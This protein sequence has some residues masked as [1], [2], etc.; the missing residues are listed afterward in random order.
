M[1]MKFLLLLLGIF[2]ITC[3][4]AVPATTGLWQNNSTSLT[5]TNGS[6]AGF[7]YYF[8]LS[9]PASLNIKLYD[10]SGN[11]VYTFLDTQTSL[12]FYYNNAPI[13]IT[14]QIYKN[15]GN[16]YLTFSANDGASSVKT[17]SLTVNPT[18]A[19]TPTNSTPVIA[20]IPPQTINENTSYNYQINALDPEGDRITYSLLPS[21]LFNI[22]SSG[23]I[24]GTS[25]NVAADTNYTI[26]IH[27]SDGLNVA[28]RT[29]NLTVKDV[30]AAID[31]TAPSIQFVL[32]T[33]S[34]NSNLFQ[35]SI[36]VNIT[37]SDSGSG[38]KNITVYLYDSSRNLINNVTSISSPFAFTFYGNSNNVA[39]SSGTYYINA[40]AFDIAGNSNSTE[41]RTIILSSNNPNPSPHLNYT[42]SDVYQ[43]QYLQQLNKTNSGINLTEQKTSQSYWEFAFLLFEILMVLVLV[44]LI[45]FVF[46]RR[47]FNQ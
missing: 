41:T 28:S 29:Y 1:K 7:N 9:S 26:T 40:T 2:L 39:L 13:M 42:Y 3:I 30:P 10:S 15:P 37:A 35:N 43:N 38:L 47:K 6:N 18:V 33:P 5:I 12:H 21:S 4:S 8:T 11:L 23:L 31:T 20:I 36:P 14:P 17:I 22:S 45:I 34:T 44:G 25:P 27:V 19:P 24:T 16:Y 46:A 32:Q